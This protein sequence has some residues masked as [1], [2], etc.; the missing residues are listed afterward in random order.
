MKLKFLLLMFL[1]AGILNAQENIIRTLIITEAH[2]GS[3]DRNFVEITNMGTEAVQLSNF[4]V[5]RAD[6]NLYLSSP[7]ASMRLPERLLQP[8]ESFFIAIV[9]DFSAD[10]AQALGLENYTPPAPSEMMQLADIQIHYSD[11][12]FSANQLGI[13]SEFQKYDS[14]STINPLGQF[15][16]R[17]AM[18]IEQHLANGDSVVIDQ[19]MGVWDTDVPE[20]EGALQNRAMNTDAADAN[21]P[22]SYDVAGFQHAGSFGT[23]I[24]KYS[25][26]E[27]NLEFVRGNSED[28]SEWI[29]L[30][31]KS[32]NL[33]RPQPWTYGNHGDYKLDENTLVPK[34]D[35]ID[36]DFA[37]KLITVPWGVRKPDGIMLAME[38]KPGI[39]WDYALSP[40]SADSITFSSRS[41]DILNIVVAGKEAYRA[42]FRIK[43][44]EPTASDN[45]VIPM[46][47]E[48]ELYSG[49][50]DFGD[51][52]WPQ[53]TTHES[54]IDTITGAGS[55]IV[56]RGLPY[57]LRVD[58]LLERLEKPVKATWEIVPVD[59][60]KSRPDL[61]EGD[62]L[63]VIAENGSV[64]EYY[65]KVSIDVGNNNAALSSITWP[66]I[67]DAELFKF[68]YGW[69]GD[70]IP[71]FTR[72]SVNYQVK[73]PFS[74][75]SVP[76]TVAKPVNLNAKVQTTR[77]SDLDGTLAER[78][79]KY[80]VTATDDTTIVVYN[81]IWQ[82]EQ[83]P[84]YI[85]PNFAEP[86][87]S[88]HVSREYFGQ[89]YLEIVNPG[90]QPLDMS[91]Y[92]IVASWSAN[93]AEAITANPEDW[94]DRFVK[95]VP[96]YKWVDEATWASKPGYLVP[97]VAVDPIVK[98]GDVFGLGAP[99]TNGWWEFGDTG[100]SMDDWPGAVGGKYGQSDVNFRE[101]W[102]NPW[103]EPVGEIPIGNLY[104]G[105]NQFIFKILNDSVKNGLKPATDPND[106]ELIESMGNVEGGVSLFGYPSQD[107]DHNF[108]SFRRKAEVNTPNPVLQASYGDSPETSEW[109]RYTRNNSGI[110]GWPDSWIL[111]AMVDYGKH[112]FI[113]S[114]DYQS[115]VSSREYKVSEGYGKDG[116]VEDISGLL[117][118]VNVSSFL[119]HI[120]KRHENQTLVV[121]SSAD[122]S[123]LAM[124][125]LI[126]L[127][128]TL[129]VTSADGANTTKYV[130]EVSEIGLSSDAVL[131]S[132]LYTINIDVEPNSASEDNAVPGSGTV[133]DFEYG[134]L[135]KTL[136][137]NITVPAGA[138]L[139]AID[140]DGNFTPLTRLNYDTTYVMV[141][142]NTNTI[143]EVVAEDGVTVINYD[144]TPAT[145]LDDA[146]ITSD[147]FN[148]I[149]RDKLVEFVPWGISVNNFLSKVAASVGA[150]LKIVDKS[151][152]ERTHGGIA[153]DD[154]VV[155]N[156][157]NE[158]VTNVYH[159][160]MLSTGSTPVTTYLAYVL[161]N[162]YAVDQVNYV[163]AGPTG[164]TQL[165][166]FYSSITPVMGATAV[167][168]GA[169]GKEK[170]SGDLAKGDMLKVTSA[171]GKMQVMYSLDVD[172][173]SA[174]MVNS[175]QISLY[176]NPTSGKINIEGVTP[177]GRI[178]VFN[179]MGAAIR[180]INI[181]GNLEI[182][183]LDDQPAGMYLIVISD[184][185]K[186]VG[187]YK[188]MR[189]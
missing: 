140:K 99:N 118:G 134:T 96:G 185:T 123:D 135:L 95:Y 57:A 85:Q 158:S 80:T 63:K 98:A 167:V 142:V 131:T 148:V 89:N 110:G 81:V 19:V 165:S 5:G 104:W 26:K 77:A 157:A 17:S 182:V 151:G 36:V 76:A 37:N 18:Y 113:P 117:T 54:G 15:F 46:M 61:I 83:D 149:Q 35:G 184:K 179:S 128:D 68:L 48:G 69:K 24:R 40:L 8:G 60:N 3:P 164:T 53:V 159:L 150:T 127:N 189:R 178:Q 84:A 175:G 59:G 156:S 65:I 45:I 187:R 154:K 13:S 87:V 125:D 122:G 30:P 102:G 23:L 155:V 138:S 168:M 86:F 91:N 75:E 144:L 133:L 136:L 121:K 34:M 79:T 2:V 173:T 6:N 97:D 107:D 70:T 33:R 143:L 132:S 29:V 82:R 64:K 106:F 147:Y 25:V 22:G 146:F 71:N 56:N 160:S 130:L 66:D 27:G 152:L 100:W 52:G 11:Y 32:D 124:G 161:S 41:G 55:S 16:G 47:N 12:N 105:Q 162:V 172:V 62:K 50:L 7:T 108:T 153:A 101:G 145:S 31:N 170:I 90:N 72:N 44:K 166:E 38:K 186:K 92:M 115:T 9:H 114:T 51:Y 163:I 39:Y 120:T 10:R 126:L 180:E 73:L 74:V 14:I 137:S 183:S 4:E 109:V 112:Y 49:I 103:G 1:F 42:A 21:N 129:V 139:T 169:D 177:G 20:L 58:T 188:V 28:D 141:I 67:P 174:K 119:S 94:V 43:V 116:T 171:D 93:P 88:E 181:Q 111:T 176:P 78:T